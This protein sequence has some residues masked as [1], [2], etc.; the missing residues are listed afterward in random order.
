M[1]LPPLTVSWEK[2][3]LESE[4]DGAAAGWEKLKP[5]VPGL[6]HENRELVDV[7]LL[8]TALDDPKGSGA[9]DS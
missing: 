7:P 1:L 6:T 8:V 3:E 4:T 2:F 9:E 5:R